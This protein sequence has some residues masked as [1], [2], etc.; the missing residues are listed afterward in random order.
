MYVYMY[1][2]T[3][4]YIIMYYMSIY[5]YI[6]IYLYMKLYFKITKNICN[7]VNIFVRFKNLFRESQEVLKTT[8]NNCDVRYYRHDTFL[9]FLN[10][11]SYM[12]TR[13][14]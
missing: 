10:F 3:Y 8:K 7:I 12:S 9:L 6:D 14:A 11:I 2:C 4:K 5:R 1:V 13:I